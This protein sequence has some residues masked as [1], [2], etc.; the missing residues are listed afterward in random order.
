MKLK[1]LSISFITCLLFVNCQQNNTDNTPTKKHEKSKRIVS[2]NGAISE[3]IAGLGYESKIVATDITSNFPESINK[4]PKVGH[5]RSIQAEGVLAQNPDVVVGIEKDLNPKVMRQ[6]KSSGVKVILFKQE[7]SVKGTKNLI[8]GIRDSLNFDIENDSLSI[9]IDQSINQLQKFENAPK[10][11][12][13]YARGAG[14]I[15][16]AGKRTQM[17]QMISI[18]G[19]QNAVNDFESFKPFFISASCFNFGNKKIVFLISFNFIPL[20][21]VEI[22]SS[23]FL[24]PPNVQFVIFFAGNLI[25]CILVPFKL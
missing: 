11:L 16:V 21:A 6:I 1:L 10:V 18:A 5:N 9:V 7:Y 12:F 14:T 4:L 24:Y 17:D 3:I 22:N 20:R 19:G 23:L 13:I 15:L 25:L 8:Q 2:L